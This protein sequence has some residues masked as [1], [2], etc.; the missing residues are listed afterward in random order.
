MKQIEKATKEAAS[1]TEAQ[2]KIVR[3]L[4]NLPIRTK[5]QGPDIKR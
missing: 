5:P 3:M 1:M 4:N 2:R